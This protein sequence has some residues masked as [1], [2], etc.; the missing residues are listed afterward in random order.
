MKIFATVF[1]VW[2]CFLSIYGMLEFMTDKDYV[3]AIK[4]ATAT[5]AVLATAMLSLYCI[6]QLWS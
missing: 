2:L 4:L 3:Q 1:F 6:T 5:V